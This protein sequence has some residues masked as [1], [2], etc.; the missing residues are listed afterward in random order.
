M[1][2]TLTI[3]QRILV[4]FMV[5][6]LTGSILQLFIAGNQLRR[7]T[8]DFYQNELETDGLEISTTLSDPLEHYRPG[9]ETGS[10]QR[11]LAHFLQD[12]DFNYLIVDR[13]FRVIGYT[14]NIGYEAV[15]RIGQTAELVTA[16]NG[17]IGADIRTGF[18]GADY[19]FVALPIEY[20]GQ[21]LGYVVLSRPMQPAYT[22]VDE[23]W[24]QLSSTTL[25]VIALVV[26]GGLWLS[27]TIS[28]PVQELRNSALKMAD[29]ALDTRID[30]DSQDEVGQLARTFN[31]MAERIEG[32]IKTQ[33][34]FVSNAAHELR[35]PLMT[36]KLRVEALADT[37]LPS[38]ERAAYMH[39]LR[40]EINHMS[41]LVSSLLVLARIDE[42][43]HHRN[44]TITDTAAA[45]R[46][47]ARHWRIEAGA[48]GLDFETDIP[49]NLPD[50]PLSSN[51][52]RLVLDNL[53]GNAVK[54]TRHGKVTLSIQHNHEQLIIQVQDS[55][56]GFKPEQAKHLFTRFY[57][58]DEVRA[59]FEGNGLGLSIAQAILNQYGATLVAKS[60]GMG[61]GATFT[62]HIPLRIVSPILA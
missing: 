42:G 50:L 51:D 57:R 8:L 32:L 22:Q 1:L 15:D 49:V 59:K 10:I 27:S 11:E 16:A 41:E 53:L 62:A 5:I 36:L 9:E 38:A 35:T 26:I 33:R 54:Y 4:T 44:G 40:D 34:S 13:S 58:S 18:D 24:L 55:G 17:Q 48:A 47:I 7:A 39:E 31:F 61:K 37:T 21:T 25:P 6:A 12:G 19:L 3:R 20:E 23:Q 45:I 60:E 46:D 56:I 52:L 43:R 28:R 2:K 14:P 29:G 30:S